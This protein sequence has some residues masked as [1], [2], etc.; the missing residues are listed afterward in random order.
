MHKNT[1]DTNN[2]TDGH[3]YELFIFALNLAEERNKKFCMPFIKPEA[4]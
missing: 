1:F 4:F 2:I 3:K